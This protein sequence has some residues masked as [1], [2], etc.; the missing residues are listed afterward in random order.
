MTTIKHLARRA[1]RLAG[2]TVLVM[3]GWLLSLVTIV[4]LSDYLVLGSFS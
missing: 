4:A 1:A 3:F 2:L